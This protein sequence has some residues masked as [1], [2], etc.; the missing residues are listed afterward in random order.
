[1]PSRAIFRESLVNNFASIMGQRLPA[2]LL[3]LGVSVLIGCESI[4]DEDETPVVLADCG[5]PLG[6][7]AWGDALP[8]DAQPGIEQEL[9]EMDSRS[10]RS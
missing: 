4:S 7:L 8:V 6:G 2:I 1:M 5:E 10:F 3:L 9:S